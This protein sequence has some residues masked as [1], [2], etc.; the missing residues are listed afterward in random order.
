MTALEVIPVFLA[1]LTFF[2]LGLDSI[3]SS[4]KNL[5]SRSMRKHAINATASPLRAAI[6]GFTFGVVSQS[7]T[8]VSFLLAGLI[9]ARLLTMQRA[10]TVVA[11]ANSGTALLAFLAAINLNL[12]IL[13]LIGITGL[14]LRQRRW[15]KW[16]PAF[17]TMLGIGLLLFGLAQLKRAASPLQESEW[18]LTVGAA[19]NGSLVLGFIGGALLRIVIQS[20]SGIVV[21]LIALCGKGILEPQQAMMV[22][23]GTGVGVGLSIIFLGQE[24]RGDSLRIAYWQAILNAISACA[25]AAWLLIAATEIVPSLVAILSKFGLTI[26]AVLATAFLIQML[27]CPLV[28]LILSSRAK[29]LLTE[30]V[31]DVVE[32]VLA[33]PHFLVDGGVDSPELAAELV[34]SEQLRV[35]AALPTLL[36]A[37]RLDK[38][39]SRGHDVVLIRES[40]ATLNS[41]ISAFIL[42]CIEQTPHDDET[43]TLLVN[44]LGHQQALAEMVT[45]V[46]SLGQEVS[47]LTAES[48]ARELGG[49][50]VEV[51]DVM[52]RTLHDAIELKD[53]FDCELLATMTSDRGDQM[54]SIRRKSATLEF[55][56]P[57]DQAGVLY[58]TSIFERIAYLMRRLAT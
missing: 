45:A 4:L 35:M 13:W 40:L 50:L 56:T 25:L 29:S 23:H 21:I 9:S 55:G 51:C 2:F 15:I 24:L 28:G 8:A 43:S 19:L 18:F 32:D 10:L 39:A 20:S 27:I 14:A 17:G 33:N 48:T 37:G 34:S 16:T 12:I 22:I 3:R 6:L 46:D 26:E 30:L 53:E 11:W 58:V 31:P 49:Q 52:L 44:A 47:T 36:D 38:D 54:E 57:K 41:E 7:A 5:A 42:E 1:G